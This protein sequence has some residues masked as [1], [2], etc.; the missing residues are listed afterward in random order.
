MTRS[1][2]QYFKV[3]AECVEPRERKN[4]VGVIA[5]ICECRQ[6]QDETNADFAY[7]DLQHSDV[8]SVGERVCEGME[9]GK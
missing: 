6:S 9:F 7:E 2:R 8:G 4:S 5:N 1:I 3:I